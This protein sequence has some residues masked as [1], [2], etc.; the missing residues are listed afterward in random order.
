MEIGVSDYDKFELY[1]LLNYLGL[2]DPWE[3]VLGKA[4]LHLFNKINEAERL[5]EEQNP[6][7]AH[8]VLLM[9]QRKTE[10]MMM[11]YNHPL[12]LYSEQAPAMDAPR[13]SR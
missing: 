11:Q 5:M 2:T 7:R 13:K 10:E 6:D 8:T 9:A 4:Y 3:T 12:E 1:E